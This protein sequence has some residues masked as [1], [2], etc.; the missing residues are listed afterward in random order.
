VV[1]TT[2]NYNNVWAVNFN[3]SQQTVCACADDEVD[4]FITDITKQGGRAI[5]LKVS[6]AFHCPLMNTASASMAIELR[7]VQFA[8]CALPVYSNINAELYADD[9]DTYKEQICTHIKSPV[10]WQKTITNMLND[11]VTT[12]IEVG[13]GELLGGMVRKICEEKGLENIMVLSANNPQSIENVIA[14]LK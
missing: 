9:P 5:R 6:G 10:Q 12:F 14:N 1:A 13:A 2:R 4:A 3:T 7:D 8:K 11:G